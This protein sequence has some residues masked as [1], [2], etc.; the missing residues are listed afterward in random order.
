MA[1]KKRYRLRELIDAAGYKPYILGEKLG[2]SRSV[3]YDW[4]HGRNTPNLRTI[5]KLAK[6]LKVSIEELVLIFVED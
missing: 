2:F 5:V 1:S 4:I 6:V 3:V